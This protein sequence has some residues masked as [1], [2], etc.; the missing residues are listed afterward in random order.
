[1][2]DALCQTG[3]ATMAERVALPMRVGAR[4]LWRL[5]RR[6]VRVPLGLRD[7]LAGA[8]PELPPLPPGADGYLV[9]SLPAGVLHDLSAQHPALRIFVRQRCRRCWADLRAG[10]EPWLAGL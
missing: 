6:L 1:M 2:D 7:V 10:F 5:R 8:L 4:T 9:T 3:A